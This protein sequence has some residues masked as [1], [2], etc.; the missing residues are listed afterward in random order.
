MLCP[1]HGDVGVDASTSGQRPMTTAGEVRGK[2]VR[3]IAW[4]IAT[5]VG[6]R[7]L[8]VAGTLAITYFVRKE[9]LG[10]VA[11]ASVVATNAHAFS[12]LGVPTIS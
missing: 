4:N 5:G 6:V 10:E 12:S 1:S 3:G 11:N 8:Q 7:A 9:A 2:A